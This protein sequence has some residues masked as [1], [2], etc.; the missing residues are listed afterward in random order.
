M[1]I[2]FT[3]MHGCGNDYIYINCFEQKINNPA[4]LSSILSDRRYSVGGDGII[5]IGP[6]DCADANMRIFNKDG[7]EGKMCGN[8]IR[9]VAK[10][11][12]DN[13]LVSSK[14]NIKIETLSGI[15]TLDIL[16]YNKKEA[17]IKVNMGRA[18]L[19]P[20]KIPMIFGKNKVINEPV[21]LNGEVYN[22]SCVSM[23]NP[24][25]VI[26]EDE[27]YSTNVKEIGSKFSVSS[28]FPEGVNVEFV[29][30]N[31]ENNISLRVWERGSGETLACG[32]GA[33]ASV[34]AAVENG[35]CKKNNDITVHLRGGKLIINYSDEGVFMTGSA[36]KVFEGEIEV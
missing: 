20:Q 33:C 7:S 12:Y 13:G 23:G 8:G 35:F 1:N 16:E 21:T 18:E 10:Y 26:F 2:K 32:S 17:L 22:I 3:K 36:V 29:S 5:L 9:C 27:I 19:D 28:M 24:H 4:E 34:V 15:K 30:V 31:D 14:N 11:L 6:S 25:C